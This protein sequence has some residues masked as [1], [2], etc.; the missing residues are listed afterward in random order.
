MPLEEILKSIEKEAAEKRKDV[1]DKTSAE[2]EEISNRANARIEK[3]RKQKQ[4]ET[5]A[6]IDDQK[7]RRLAL[8]RLDLRNGLLEVKH[9]IINEVFEQAFEKIRSMPDKKYMEL[10][11]KLFLDFA[12]PGKGRV[13]IAGKDQD[14]ILPEFI[15]RVL[16][17]L[18]ES[19]REYDYELAD[20]DA[21]IEGGFIIETRNT[22]IDCSLEAL[23]LETR[24][25]LERETVEFLFKNG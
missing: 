19:G 6:E 20:D 21:G 23:F 13:Y 10:V 5:A 11:E 9:E 17:K 18:N 25:R 4:A 2:T 16:E 22:K 8:K 7:K 15:S 14:R 12:E 24:N 1:E 3:L